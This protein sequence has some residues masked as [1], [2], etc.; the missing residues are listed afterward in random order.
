[1]NLPKRKRIHQ[2][3]VGPPENMTPRS[4]TILCEKDVNKYCSRIRKKVYC[5]MDP[6]YKTVISYQT[7][8]AKYLRVFDLILHR[9]LITQKQPPEVFCKK[10]VQFSKFQSETPA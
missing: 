2:K 1:M 7:F 10:G 8:V 9:L 4:P 5:L 3:Y 6:G